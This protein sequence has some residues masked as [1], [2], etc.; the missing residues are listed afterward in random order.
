MAKYRDPAF[1]QRRLSANSQ[2]LAMGDQKLLLSTILTVLEELNTQVEK[3]NEEVQSL[4][5]KGNPKP[6]KKLE[7]DDRTSEDS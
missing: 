4:R 1:W 6:R 7:A 3:L 2:P 5:S